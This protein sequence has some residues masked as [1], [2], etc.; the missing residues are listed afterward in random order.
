[1]GR[2]GRKIR[3][4]SLLFWTGTTLTPGVI[5]IFILVLFRVW[6]ASPPTSA[7]KAHD[8]IYSG[9]PGN[10][11]AL[12]ELFSPNGDMGPRKSMVQA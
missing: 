5:K 8:E 11:Q 1:M 9:D 4:N 7:M 2:W 10:T 6:M 12:R 3:S